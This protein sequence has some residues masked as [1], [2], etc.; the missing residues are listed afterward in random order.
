MK[1]IVILDRISLGDDM[2]ISVFEQ[3]GELVDYAFTEEREIHERIF[4]ADI[5]ITNKCPMNQSTLSG[6]SVRLI[7]LTATGTNNV[8]LN[9]CRE[10]RIAVCNVRGYSTESVVQ[11]TFALLLS[12][13]NQI[14]PFARHVQ[15]GLF[16]NDTSYTHLKWIYHE[17]NGKE[18]GVIGLGAIGAR[19]AQT[20]EIFGC[21]VSYWSSTDSDRSKKYSRLTFDEIIRQSDIISIHSP[22]T[23]RT[24]H[25]FDKRAFEKMKPNAVI[26]NLGRGDLIV[27]DDLTIAIE[28]RLIAGAGLDV[29]SKEPMNENSPYNRILHYPNFIITPHVGWAAVE[30]RT[31]CIEEIIMN[32]EAFLHNQVRNRVD[33]AG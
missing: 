14:I 16:I 25:L 1:K 6:S 33:I 13:T 5:I 7:C 2:N 10:N 22:L 32:I 8:D 26:L 17:I 12:L 15:N 30:S 4:D 31:R 19:V 11:H 18:F 20:A 27:E 29:L 23:E 21:K 24:K 28:Q 9:Y 3:F